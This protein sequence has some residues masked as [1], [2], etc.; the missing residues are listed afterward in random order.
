M[1]DRSSSFK[2]EL[3]NQGELLYR[4]RGQSM[5]PLIRQDRDLIL[6]RPRPEGQ[7]RKYDVILYKKGDRY[8]LHRIL[9]VLEDGYVVCGDHNWK[10]D[11]LVTDGEILGILVAVI[12]NGKEIGIDDFWYRCY[13]HLW[14]DFFPLRALALRF[15]GKLRWIKRKVTG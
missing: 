2:E 14:C 9:K 4:N 3:C 15:T 10:K 8:I 7:C 12:R 1:S 6:I 13:V 5:L 11:P